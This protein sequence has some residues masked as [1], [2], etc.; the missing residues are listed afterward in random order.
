MAKEKKRKKFFDVE[1]PLIGKETHLQAYDIKDLEGKN[2]KYDLTRILKGKGMIMKLK[3]K[4]EGEKAIAT[5]TE[6]K[7][8][9]YFLKRMVRKGTNYVED[10]FSVECKN[11]QLRIKPFLIT[12]RK[13]SRAVRKA[14]RNKAKEEL[15]E[16]VKDKDTELLFDEILKN[17]IQKPLS[18]K[19]KKIYPLSLCEI[20]IFKI[21]KAKEKILK[22]PVKKE[23]KKEE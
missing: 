21:E 20:R 9:P 15:I 13:V 8:M 1:I 5:P 22:E 12:R 23:E 18:L 17:Q 14:L 2:I 6:T 19:L 11:A 3:V 10:S 4:I 7:L 16:H